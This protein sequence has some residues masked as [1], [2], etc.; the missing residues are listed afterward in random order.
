MRTLLAY[1]GSRLEDL[2][3]TLEAD[4]IRAGPLVG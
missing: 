3:V 4:T 2:L 1:Y